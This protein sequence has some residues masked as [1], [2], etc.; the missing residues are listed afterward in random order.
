MKKPIKIFIS[1]SWE[2]EIFYQ[3]LVTMLNSIIDFNWVNLSISKDQAISVA[4][5]EEAIPQRIEFLNNRSA[6][7]TKLKYKFS[8]KLKHL[9]ARRANLKIKEMEII[10]YEQIDLLIAE[11]R[12]RILNPGFVAKIKSLEKIKSRIEGL[13][14]QREKKRN[15][16]GLFQ[17]DVEIN[18]VEKR[19]AKLKDE[20]EDINQCLNNITHIRIGN[21]GKTRDDVIK[22]FPNLAL[23]IRNQLA[24]ADLVLIVVQSNSSYQ[25]WIEYEYQE[26]FVLRKPIIGLLHPDLMENIPPDLKRYG[27]IPIEWDQ[28]KLAQ[29]LREIPEKVLL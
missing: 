1:H 16:S 5:G 22:K 27:V 14:L 10:Q 23:A 4:T 24:Q 2:N 20:R 15:Q 7:I 21:T 6:E 8:N 18:K 17:L 13:N 19:V 26:A 3:N 28:H 9:K 25:Q 12:E 29:V 11:E